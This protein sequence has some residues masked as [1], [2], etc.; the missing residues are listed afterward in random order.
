V[1]PTQ[2]RIHASADAVPSHR[3]WNQMQLTRLLKTTP[4]WRLVAPGYPDFARLLAQE[5]VFYQILAKRP[6][7]GRCLNAGCGGGL[8]CPFLESFEAVTSIDNIDISDP[9]SI[10]IHH[11]DSRHRFAQ[12]SLTALPYSD[13]VF[14]SCLCSEVLEHI[15]DHCRAVAE[16]ARVLRPKGILL[17]SVPQSPAPWD[18]AHV[19]QGY[20]YDEMRELLEG[21]G[22]RILDRRDC[23][24][25]FLRWIMHYWRKPWVRFGADQTPYLP[26]L[27]ISALVRLDRLIHPGSPWDLVILAERC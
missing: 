12:G 17:L 24:Y 9:S 21:Q 14:D 26:Q 4:L 8:F 13:S 7:S 15:D 2:F 6:L 19:R 27:V 10:A 18:P 11:T 5:P 1:S 25:G 23:F 22:F 20:S 16:F 3:T